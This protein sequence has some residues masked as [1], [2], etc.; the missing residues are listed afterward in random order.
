LTE[1]LGDDGRA[2]A[3]LHDILREPP[4]AIVRDAA[5]KRFE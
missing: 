5:I 4:S 3:T 2:V 1:R